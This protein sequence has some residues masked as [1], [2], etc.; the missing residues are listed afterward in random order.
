MLVVVLVAKDHLQHLKF[1]IE[2]VGNR[3]NRNERK[4]DFLQTDDHKLFVLITRPSITIFEAFSFVAKF[5]SRG[6]NAASVN[7]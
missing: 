2:I 7:F 4:E 5:S 6:E 1:R 3:F